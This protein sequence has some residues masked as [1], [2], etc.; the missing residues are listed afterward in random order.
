[1]VDEDDQVADADA[2]RGLT[3]A[4]AGWR[5]GATG[6]VG[7]GGAEESGG[8][9]PKVR[10]D[11]ARLLEGQRVG[12][13]DREGRGGELGRGVRPAGFVEEE[14]GPGIESDAGPDVDDEHRAAVAEIG[15]MVAAVTG[16]CEAELGAE[17]GVGAKTQR[18][19]EVAAIGDVVDAVFEELGGERASLPELARMFE[20]LFHDVAGQVEGDD[21]EA[22]RGEGML[23]T[24]EGVGDGAVVDALY[25][26]AVE[27]VE[28]G[29]VAGAVVE[30]LDDGGIGKPEGERGVATK[31]SGKEAGVEDGEERGRRAGKGVDA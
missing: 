21:G 3:E 23:V 7:P 6:G 29:A 13:L 14:E 10:G 8:G 12:V 1:M 4:D 30:S 28:S 26:E 9:A 5:R 24:D 18:S 20:P 27:V 19:V 25:D 22:A 15:S 11:L 17:G 2:L 31:A 16:E